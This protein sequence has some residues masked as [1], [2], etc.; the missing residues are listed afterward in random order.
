M[1]LK[2]KI[3]QIKITQKIPVEVVGQESELSC[4][5]VLEIDHIIKPITK[6]SIDTEKEK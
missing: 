1:A 3:K 6:W 4:Q 2:G 5:F